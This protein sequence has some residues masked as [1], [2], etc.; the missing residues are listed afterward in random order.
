MKRLLLLSF[1]VIL[2]SCNSSDNSSTP[3]PYEELFHVVAEEARLFDVLQKQTEFDDDKYEGIEKYYTL[4]AYY[5]QII[6]LKQY[7]DDALIGANL[8]GNEIEAL[9]SS[10]E[11]VAPARNKK[12]ILKKLP[13]EYLAEAQLLARELELIRDEIVLKYYRLTQDSIDL[14]NLVFIVQAA[15]Q[16][17]RFYANTGC[18]NS[19]ELPP[20]F[21]LPTYEKC[22]V[23]DWDSRS[24]YVKSYKAN[25]V[26]INTKS[27]MGYNLSLSYYGACFSR[28]VNDVYHEDT[29]TPEVALSY[30][31]EKSIVRYYSNQGC[32]NGNLITQMEAPYAFSS[33]SYNSW[34]LSSTGLSNFVKSYKIDNKCV[35]TTGST[36][37]SLAVEFQTMCENIYYM[38]G[39]N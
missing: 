38:V 4:L 16:E 8:S 37:Y 10:V 23:R 26:C 24:Q 3:G 18:S 14:S 6:V 22:S 21:G 20:I 34:Q 9:I 28:I 1:F 29:S 27:S 19:S 25:G 15:P 31:N 7:M 36:G 17:Y 33:C 32:S 11:F 39:G 2:V 35:N 30:L 5:K 12:V 13:S